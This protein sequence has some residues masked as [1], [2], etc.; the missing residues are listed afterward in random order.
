MSYIL[1]ALKKAEAERHAGVLDAAPLPPGFA[2]TRR[3]RRARNSRQW[4]WPALSVL[5]VGGAGAVWLATTS[6]MPSANGNRPVPAASLI[7]AVPAA[8]TVSAVTAVPAPPPPAPSATSAVAP[9]PEPA[10][11]PEKPKKKVA[12]KSPEKK[13]PPPV[14]ETTAVHAPEHNDNTSIAALHDLPE[15]VRREI[16]PLAVGG[17]IYSGNRADRSVLVN[18]RLLREGDEIAPGLTLEQMT[19]SGMV[20]NYKGYRYRTSY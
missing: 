7:P 14:R 4:L 13:Q 12:R 18:K 5:A 19:P 11:E 10:E 1:E 16:P 17:Y 8:P 20:L 3:H 9:P 6:S 15:H 2:S